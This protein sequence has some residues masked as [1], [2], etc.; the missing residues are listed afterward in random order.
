MSDLDISALRM[1]EAP[2]PRRPLGPRVAVVVLT[3]VVLAVAATFLVP[4]PTLLFI[5]DQRA[6]VGA[7]GGKILGSGQGKRES[8]WRSAG[9][10]WTTS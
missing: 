9:R 7:I 4:L 6:D 2:P 1:K 10:S 5:L 8:D 3:L